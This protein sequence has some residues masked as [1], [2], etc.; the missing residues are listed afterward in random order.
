MKTR[1][2]AVGLV[3][4]N[5]PLQVIGTWAGHLS[6]GL[7][8]LGF[9]TAVPI[10]LGCT[11]GL[12]AAQ[13]A[14]SNVT[15]RVS[16]AFFVADAIPRAP[17]SVKAAAWSKVRG[18]L[19]AAMACVNEIPPRLGCD[20][21]S[22]ALPEL[23]STVSIRAQSEQD[24]MALGIARQLD[25]VWT[26][27]NYVLRVD[28]IRAQANFE[29]NAPFEWRRFVVKRVAQDSVVFAIGNE[30]FEGRVRGDQ[31]ALTGTNFQGE[32]LLVRQ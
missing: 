22:N 30:V 9:L 18:R 8:F 24:R 4:S 20:Q 6:K 26:S 12:D 13:A 10:L 2:S 31:V 32:R 27:G 29:P 5:P 1:H 19:F 7:L 23:I 25:G 15:K 16:A 17:A 28:G 21:P 3:C 14:S 11:M